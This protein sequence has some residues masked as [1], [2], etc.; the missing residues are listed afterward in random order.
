MGLFY[1]KA[2]LCDA[3]PKDRIVRQI[4]ELVKK[5]TIIE[6]NS[7]KTFYRISLSNGSEISEAEN[8]TF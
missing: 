7:I 6:R 3:C 8:V 4:C 1:V 5:K 2:I